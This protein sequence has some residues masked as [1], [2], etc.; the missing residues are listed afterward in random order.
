MYRVLQSFQTEISSLQW[1]YLFEQAKQHIGVNG[2]LV[3]LVQHND[4]ILAQV[5]VNQTLSQ[6]HTICH[7]L[8]D[9]VWTCAVLKSDSVA[10]LCKQDDPMIIITILS[11]AVQNKRNKHMCWIS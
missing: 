2:P 7:V 1:P 9:C 11:E 5:R 8:D 4:G 10:H 3:S 6:Q